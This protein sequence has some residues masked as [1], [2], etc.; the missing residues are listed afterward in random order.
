MTTTA[1]L[2]LTAGTWAIDN[3]HSSVEFVVRHMG[4]SKVRGRFADFTAELVVGADL[5]ACSLTADVNLA[6]VDTNNADRDA[7]LTGTDF[8]D[9]EASPR[10]T[11][12]STAIEGSDGE[13]TATGDLT[14]RG[15]TK[16][17]TLDI[18]FNG[19]ETFPF[20]QSVH[21]GFSATG[22]ISRKDFGIEFEVPLGA[23]KVM[24]GDKVQ[25]EL[26]AQFAPAG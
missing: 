2:P 25:I 13:Y 9:A 22:S 18:E 1:T 23:D 6:S 14:I 12:V 16:P 7:H 17:V 20:D 15:V 10:M 19:T 21:A 4:L 8:F 5:S 26:E 24:I 11:F 3:S